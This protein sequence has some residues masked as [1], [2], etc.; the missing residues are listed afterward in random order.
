MKIA[1]IYRE[2][3][4]YDRVERKIIHT[5]QHY[6]YEMSQAFFDDLEIPKPAFFLNA[7]SGAHAVQ[8]AKIMV[9]F[10]K[11]C[12]KKKPWLVMV[13]GD[14]ANLNNISC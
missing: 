3:L 11:L 6:D 13:V 2:S 12:Q 1:S 8:A 10:E 5:G 14:V 9:A 4:N 7:G